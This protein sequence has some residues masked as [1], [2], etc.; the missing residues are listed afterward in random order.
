LFF[1][2][3]SILFRCKKP[4]LV[5]TA[6]DL[7]EKISFKSDNIKQKMLELKKKNF[8]WEKKN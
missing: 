6:I 4:Q 7:F 2:F 1:Q 8:A 5:A 3:F